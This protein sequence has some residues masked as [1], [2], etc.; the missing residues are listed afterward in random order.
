MTGQKDASK[1]TGTL[2]QGATR[3]DN[4]GWEVRGPSILIADVHNRVERRALEQKITES[5]SGDMPGDVHLITLPLSRNKKPPDPGKLIGK[6]TLVAS[7]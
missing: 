4:G 3:S 2:Q 7:G 5:A 1:S 6:L